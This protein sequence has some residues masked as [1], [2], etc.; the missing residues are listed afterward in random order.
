MAIRIQCCARRMLARHRVVNVLRNLAATRIQ[1]LW[2]GVVDRVLADRLWLDKRVIPIQCAARR[3]VAKNKFS[4]HYNVLNQAALLIQ[5]KFRTILAARKVG[6]ILHER[7]MGYR[8]NL[9]R[10]LTAEE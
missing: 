1:A 4:G 7:E 5:R 10:L 6:N 9:V 8:M 3:M 2:R